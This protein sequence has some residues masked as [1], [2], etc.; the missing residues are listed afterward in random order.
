V[1]FLFRQNSDKF[2]SSH[3]LSTKTNVEFFE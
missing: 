3:R 1:N 2:F